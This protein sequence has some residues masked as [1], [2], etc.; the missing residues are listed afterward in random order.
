VAYATGERGIGGD[1]LHAH[2]GRGERLDYA[3][4]GVVMRVAHFEP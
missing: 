1:E 3:S 4:Q 2:P